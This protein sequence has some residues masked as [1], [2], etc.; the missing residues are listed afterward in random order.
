MIAVSADEVQSDLR[1]VLARAHAGEV[2]SIEEDGA[3]LA[4]LIP[5]SAGSPTKGKRVTKILDGQSRPERPP[6]PRLGMLKGKGSVPDNWKELGREEIE[7]D[8]PGE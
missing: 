5:A 4:Q 3:T 8:F 7:R 6:H 1:G 2:I